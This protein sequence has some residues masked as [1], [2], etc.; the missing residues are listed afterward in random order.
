[1]IT[2]LLSCKLIALRQ[3]DV[4]AINTPPDATGS[5]SAKKKK[6]R[7]RGRSVPCWIWYVA[8]S[9]TTGDAVAPSIWM[10]AGYVA[11]YGWP[12]PPLLHRLWRS[13]WIQFQIPNCLEKRLWEERQP[14]TSLNHS[15]PADGGWRPC[16]RPPGHHRKSPRLLKIR[17][18]RVRMRGSGMN[19][20]WRYIY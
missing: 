1:M 10:A 8:S 18:I 13:D 2:D 20:Y 4:P 9:P 3:W 5:Y 15:L 17:K 19:G 12:P 11:A 7:T 6:K 16:R 14:T